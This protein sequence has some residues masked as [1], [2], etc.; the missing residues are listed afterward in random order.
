MKPKNVKTYLMKCYWISY[1]YHKKTHP[2]N[3]RIDREELEMTIILCS[4]LFGKS[5]AHRHLIK[6]RLHHKGVKWFF[7]NPNKKKKKWNE[8]NIGWNLRQQIKQ[9]TEKVTK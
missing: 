9:N 1:F 3:R 8:N 4:A 6:C 2:Y 5:A 7:K